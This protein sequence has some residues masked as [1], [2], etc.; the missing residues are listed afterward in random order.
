MEA[1]VD[2]EVRQGDHAGQLRPSDRTTSNIFEVPAF[3]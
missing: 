2:P 3:A 1:L